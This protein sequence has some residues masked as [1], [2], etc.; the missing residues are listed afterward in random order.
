MLGSSGDEHTDFAPAA[1]IEVVAVLILPPGCAI[2]RDTS[3]LITIILV[4]VAAWAGPQIVLPAREA[5]GRSILGPVTFEVEEH[6]SD[7]KI[8]T[9]F[10]C[11]LLRQS[12][13]IM[14]EKGEPPAGQ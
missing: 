4:A 11:G 5:K 6:T 14:L 9:S 1:S 12:R 7:P 3:H 2:C 13:T 10:G 8:S